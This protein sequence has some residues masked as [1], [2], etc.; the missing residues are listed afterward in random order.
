MSPKSSRFLLYDKCVHSG[1]RCSCAEYWIRNIYYLE[2]NSSMSLG[3]VPDFRFLLLCRIFTLKLTVQP[4]ELL[5]LEVL[6]CSDNIFL[7]KIYRRANLEALEGTY[8]TSPSVFTFQ[9]PLRT[10]FKLSLILLWVIPSRP[11][12]AVSY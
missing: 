3:Y 6:S 5:L 4:D 8:V 10:Q 1:W 11:Q 7:E 2:P 9:I 12:R